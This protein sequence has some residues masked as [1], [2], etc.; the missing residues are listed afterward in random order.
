MAHLLHC[1]QVSWDRGNAAQSGSDDRFYDNRNYGLWAQLEEFLVQFGL[2][3]SYKFRIR[4][5]SHP[6]AVGV[7]SC[8]PVSVLEEDGLERGSTNHMPGQGERSN[9]GSMV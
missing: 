6:L 8:N 1:F 7:T 2:F 4:L 9:G 3:A 5:T